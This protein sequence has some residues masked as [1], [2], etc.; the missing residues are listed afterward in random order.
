MRLLRSSVLGVAAMLLMATTVFAQVRQDFNLQCQ[1]TVFLLDYTVPYWGPGTC[2]PPAPYTTVGQPNAGWGAAPACSTGGSFSCNPGD[3][4]LGMAPTGTGTG[5]EDTVASATQFITAVNSFVGGVTLNAFVVPAG[6]LTPTA[7]KSITV[8]VDGGIQLNS[9]VVGSH[10]IA[11]VSLQRVGTNP[12]ALCTRQVMVQNSVVQQNNQ[13][14]T[15][16]CVDVPPPGVH[17]Y[18]IAV[19][20]LVSNAPF[21]IGGNSFGSRVRISATQNGF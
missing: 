21:F 3:T 20:G 12:A 1:D 19:Q 14:F 18:R 5:Q 11:T 10:G 17:S 13:P 8:T 4:F 15:I 6:A 9:A 2:I 7:Q 16:S